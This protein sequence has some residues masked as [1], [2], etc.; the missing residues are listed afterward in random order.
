[1]VDT[2]FY[3]EA[4]ARADA[5]L[6]EVGRLREEREFDPPDEEDQDRTRSPDVSP[7]HSRPIGGRKPSVDDLLQLQRAQARQHVGGGMPGVAAALG[8]VAGGLASVLAGEHTYKQ[9]RDLEA[10]FLAGTD[11]LGKA[12]HV[13]Q[14]GLRL[15]LARLE[16]RVEALESRL[17][18]QKP[19]DA[20]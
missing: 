17:N 11:E 10:K 6:D 14:P 8:G 3:T 20:D 1:M 9:Q 18:A 15:R 19:P 2:T 4:R 13:R 5:V 12:G 7:L 16:R